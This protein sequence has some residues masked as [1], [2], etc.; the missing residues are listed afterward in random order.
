MVNYQLVPHL[1]LS[2]YSNYLQSVTCKCLLM[3]FESTADWWKHYIKIDFLQ[4]KYT[5]TTCTIMLMC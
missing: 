5:D 4:L 3:V 2:I 1:F